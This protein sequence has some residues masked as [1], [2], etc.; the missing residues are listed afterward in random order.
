MTRTRTVEACAIERKQNL[1][2]RLIRVMIG[3]LALS[4]LFRVF[5]DAA[6]FLKNEKRIKEARRKEC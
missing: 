5:P 2:R 3:I 4:N 6:P 1:S